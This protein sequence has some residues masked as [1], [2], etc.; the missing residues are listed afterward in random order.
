MEHD[1]PQKSNAPKRDSGDEWKGNPT[2]S[3]DEESETTQGAPTPLSLPIPLSPLV[4]GIP[5]PYQAYPMQRDGTACAICLRPHPPGKCNSAESIENLQQFRKMIQDPSNT[6][7]P[8]VKVRPPLFGLV[9][10][11]HRRAPSRKTHSSLLTRCWQRDVALSHHEKSPNT[12]LQRVSTNAQ[13]PRGPL[14]QTYR[15]RRRKSS[16]HQQ[17]NRMLVKVRALVT[18]PAASSQDMNLSPQNREPRHWLRAHKRLVR[19]P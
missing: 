7:H 15:S 9:D 16:R 13:H 8:D 14:G 10:E 5:A 4:N 6:E 18:L 3:T 11:T 17:Q 1:S 19:S 12:L 2:A